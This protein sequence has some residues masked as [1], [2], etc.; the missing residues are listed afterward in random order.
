VEKLEK[1]EKEIINLVEDYV[2][3]KNEH[4]KHFVPGIT[5]I[6]VSGRVLDE[7]DYKNLISS[8]LDGWLTAGEYTE[9]F[10]KKLRSYLNCRHSLM[11][12]SGSSANLVI[13]TGIKK[14]LDLNDGDEVITSGVNFPT[15][16][17][18]ILQNNL[19]PVLIDVE[20]G[21]YNINP[22]LIEKAITKKTKGIVLAHTL[23]NPFD[24]N[25]ILEICEKYNLFLMEDCCDALGA[26]Y[27]NKTVGNFGLAGSLSFYPA[28]HITTGEGGAVYTNNAKLKKIM[29]SIRDW[30]RDCYCPPGVDNTCKKRYD[31]QLGE[32]P[33]GYDHKYTYSNIGYN[34]KSSDLQASIGISQLEKADSFIEKRNSNFEKLYKYFSEFD[35]F[36]LPKKHEKSEPSWFGFP[37][38]VKKNSVGFNRQE[39]LIHY[40]E[41]N[42]GNRLLFAGNIKKQPAYEKANIKVSG[43][44]QNSDIVMNDTFWL[45]V[46]PG[47]TDEMIDYIYKSTKEF[48][49][50]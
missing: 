23:G 48:L 27:E 8:S 44:L 16:L 18:P 42:I 47:L 24:V 32:L 11:V 39:L 41:H 4:S 14:L 43:N 31:W 10:E 33:H 36:I 45:G 49:T 29:E 46:Y 2:S 28:H 21:S 38:T 34:L 37:L 15:T 3:A 35:Q 26:K 40:Q 19:I 50:K 6:P 22:E 9:I 1:I 13:M 30:G 7:Y 25:A 17:N 5:H 20:I 12:N